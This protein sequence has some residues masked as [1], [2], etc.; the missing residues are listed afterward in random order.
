L[1]PVPLAALLGV[2]ALP[3]LF[4]TVRFAAAPAIDLS[5]LWPGLRFAVIGA[6]VAV[7]VGGVFGAMAGTL[8]LPGRRSAIGLGTLLLA[9]PPAFW[10]IGLTR[11]PGGFGSVSGVLGGS[12][13]AGVALAPI[14]L[15]LVLAASREIP[16][17]VYQAARLSLDPVRRVRWV[18]LPLLRPA[19]TAGFLLTLILLLGESEIPFLFGFRTSMTD[20]VTTF[21]QTFA[22]DS[23]LPLVV[24]LLA[25]V[26]LL[27]LLMA[28]AL[29]AVLAAAPAPGRGVIRRSAGALIAIGLLPL[30]AFAASSLVGYGWAF[31]SNG[32]S[33]GRRWPMDLA[34]VSVSIAEPVLCALAGVALAISA[35]YTVRRSAAIRPLMLICLLLFC[36]PAAIVAVGWV[37]VSRAWGSGSVAPAIAHVAR[38]IAL[39]GLG[40]LVAYSRLPPSFEQAARLVPLSSVRRAWILMLPMLAP[41]II[42]ASAM[43]AAFIFSDR[44]VASLLLAPGQSRLMLNLYLLS[45]NAP[46]AVV[47]G[48][49]LIVF[50]AGAVVIATAAF[51]PFMLLGRQRD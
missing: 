48:T 7:V 36:V 21:S 19:L 51:V 15:L 16:A 37:G 3:L 50:G 10:W 5:S 42:A 30:P 13:V 41:S 24:P 31:L 28:R 1:K 20:I 18:L 9:A 17:N 11:L 45:A 32:S 23:T 39:P 6:A 26:L 33:G 4:L 22:P 14:T 8:D 2:S 29:F 35:S 44:D 12:A 27:A 43:T 34:T 38:A 40:F 47:G 49:A 25:V 46:S